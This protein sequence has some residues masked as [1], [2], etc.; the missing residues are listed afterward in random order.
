M[1]KKEKT[2]TVLLDSS[3]AILLEKTD[4]LKL[5]LGTYEVILTRAVFD[6]LTNNSYPSARLFLRNYSNSH[7]RVM[8]LP[9]SAGNY[10]TDE[11]ASLNWGERETI[12]QFLSGTGDFI[13][14]DDGKAAKYC[15]KH[16]LP[17]INTLL[18][19]IILHICGILPIA[20]RQAKIEEIVAIGRYSDKIEE[21]ALGFGSKE[22]EPF[23]P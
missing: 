1:E 7:F 14:L 22:L 15:T 19:P 16:K 17:F 23:F 8:T 10:K 21:M 2:K 5:F 9:E 6:E 13:M 18:F 12:L 3:S 4:L 11:L 20:E